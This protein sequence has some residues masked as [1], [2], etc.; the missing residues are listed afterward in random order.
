VNPTTRRSAGIVL[1]RR[2]VDGIEVLL[3]HMGGPYWARKDAGAWSIPKGEYGDDEEPFVAACREFEEE[4]GCPVPA[5]EFVD[6]GEMRQ[7]GG[8]VVRAW[9]AE[10]SP[11]AAFDPAAAV[12]TTFDLEWPPRSGRIQQF[13][14]IDRVEWF[15]VARTAGLIVA[16][17]RPFLTRLA[18]HL[19]R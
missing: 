13:P 8:K 10:L 5:A 11:D 18:D 4:I 2:G 12:S 14:E 9:A 6:L 19:Q 3:G 15:E 1:Y 16:G 7:A 17:Q